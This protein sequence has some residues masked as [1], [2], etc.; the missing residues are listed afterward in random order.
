[1]QNDLKLEF[2][3]RLTELEVTQRDMSKDVAKHDALLDEMGT[4]LTTLVLEVKQIRNAL[5]LMAAA[6]AANVPA[7][8]QLVQ[9]LKSVLP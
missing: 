7:L 1:M 9:Y 2:A 6:V 4:K 5:Y 8:G 3:E